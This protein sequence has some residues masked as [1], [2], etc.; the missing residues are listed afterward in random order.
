[1]RRGILLRGRAEVNTYRIIDMTKQELIRLLVRER[2]LTMAAVDG[3]D[4]WSAVQTI[5][6]EIAVLKDT[7]DPRDFYTADSIAYAKYRAGAGGCSD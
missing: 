3:E 7:L 4:R 5:R 6:A 2:Q 1:V